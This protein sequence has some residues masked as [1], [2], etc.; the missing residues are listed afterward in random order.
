MEKSGE[1]KEE[2]WVPWRRW[3]RGARGGS[4]GCEDILNFWLERKGM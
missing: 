2:G 4:N 3:L 1:G